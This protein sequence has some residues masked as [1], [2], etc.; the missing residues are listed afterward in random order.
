M[1]YV[2]CSCAKQPAPKQCPGRTY[3]HVRLYISLR[4]LYTPPPPI[5]ALDVSAFA[6]SSP[7]T[8]AFTVHSLAT[9]VLFS[10]TGPAVGPIP[11]CQPRRP[12]GHLTG[13]CKWPPSSDKH[14]P[15]PT[16]ADSRS[17]R[18]EEHITSCAI[19]PALNMR[20]C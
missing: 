19:Q 6:T 16:S 11:T 20:R 17:A 2:R 4:P 14:Q 1:K 13:G 12:I 5:S 18:A 3:R 7:G 8:I 9:R 10:T 15:Q